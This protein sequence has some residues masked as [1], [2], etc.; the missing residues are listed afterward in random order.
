MFFKANIGFYVENTLKMVIAHRFI[1]EN[2][3]ILQTGFRVK[4]IITK[5]LLLWKV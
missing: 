3:N 4:P 2:C 5:F 1:L